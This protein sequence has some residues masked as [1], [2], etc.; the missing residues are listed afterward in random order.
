MRIGEMSRMTGAMPDQ[1]R[2][3]ESKGFIT[4]QKLPLRHRIVKDYAE[5]D[6]EKVHLIANFLKEG[7]RYEVAHKRALE[8]LHQ[9]RLF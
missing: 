8:Q 6:V 4:A 9:P 3:L 5:S 2:Y 7:I 1:I